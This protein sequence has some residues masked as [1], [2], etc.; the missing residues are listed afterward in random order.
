MTSNGCR[1]SR[2]GGLTRDHMGDD[3]LFFF[4]SKGGSFVPHLH[5]VVDRRGGV[6]GV[7]RNAFFFL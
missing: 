1:G 3:G 2:T 5:E 4:F 7:E 6:K